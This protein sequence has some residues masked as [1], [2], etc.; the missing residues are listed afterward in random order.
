MKQFFR[1]LPINIVRSFTGKNFKWHLL[2]YLLTYIIV[3]SGLDWFYFLNTRSGLVGGLAFPAFVIGGFLPI[4]LP[5][6]V[7]ASGYIHKHH[8]TIHTAWVMGQAAM[9][10][11]LISTTY[12]ALTGR[13]QPNSSNTLLDISHQ[14]NFGFLKH[15]VF[16]GWPSS[17]TTVAFA[18][19]VSLIY[20]YP[21]NKKLIF[22][23]LLYAFYIGLAVAT[24]I[25][26]FSEFVAGAI[27]GSVIGRVV[28]KRFSQN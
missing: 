2:A 11:Y 14:F 13:I 4:V 12:K 27:I 19:S 17:H 7:L 20:L 8:K 21:K 28:G 6:V 9:I 24:R 5:L 3:V 10:A 18:V 16:W 15:G 22:I 25:H 1:T 23:A 26:W